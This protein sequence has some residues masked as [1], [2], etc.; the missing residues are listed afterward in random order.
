MLSGLMGRY[1]ERVLRR[2]NP[3]EGD[4]GCASGML[5]KRKKVLAEVV[6]QDL[7]KFSVSTSDGLT[8]VL[9]KSAVA[10]YCDEG[11]WARL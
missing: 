3:V 9:W 8:V 7:P 4:C 6:V 2:W 1:V 10:G 5:L 11:L